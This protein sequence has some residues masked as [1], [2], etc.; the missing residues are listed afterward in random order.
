MGVSNYDTANVLAKTGRL[1]HRHIAK[2]LNKQYYV[3]EIWRTLG[4]R[5]QKLEMETVLTITV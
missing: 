1:T 3:R 5:C 4:T 2:S